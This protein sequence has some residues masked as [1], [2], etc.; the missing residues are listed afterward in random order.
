MGR[1][2]GRETIILD[3]HTVPLMGLIGVIA[4]GLNIP[5]GYLR[6]GHRKYSLAWFV[7]IHLSI[8]LIA[9]LRIANHITSWF[10]P[11]F[12]LC[13]VAGQIVGGRFRRGED[14]GAG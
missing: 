13:A 11:F 4:L 5:L 3:H 14:T 2:D 10:I 7:Y 12:L 1:S 9:Y 8:P 6:E